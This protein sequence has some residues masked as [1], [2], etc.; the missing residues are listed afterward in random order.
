LGFDN[1]RI[2]VIDGDNH[3]GEGL[4]QG[5]VYGFGR[6]VRNGAIRGVA[7]IEEAIDEGNDRPAGEF[8]EEFEDAVEE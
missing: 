8:H 6:G 2:T 7:G 5:G 3:I 1:I 4:A